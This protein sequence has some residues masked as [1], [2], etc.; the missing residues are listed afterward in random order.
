MQPYNGAGREQD[1]ELIFLRTRQ[2]ALE[3]ILEHRRQARV[4][5][6]LIHHHHRGRKRPPQ[7]MQNLRLNGAREL[8]V[9]RFFIIGV[10]NPVHQTHA[11]GARIAFGHKAGRRRAKTAARANAG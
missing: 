2:P 9:T 10:F 8:I 11:L 7:R 3:I 1:I 6:I 5:C 4:V